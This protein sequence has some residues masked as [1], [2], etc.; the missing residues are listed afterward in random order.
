MYMKRAIWMAVCATAVIAV[1]SLHG[2]TPAGAGQVTTLGQGAAAAT[3]DADALVSRMLRSDDLRVR[4]DRD[5]TLIVGRHIEQLTQYY[6]GARVWGG[7]VARQR[8]GDTAVSVFGSI[9]QGIDLDVT[10]LLGR[11][12]AAARLLS[13]GSSLLV[14]DREPELVVLPEDGG[15]FRLVWVG[16]VLTSNNVVRFFIDANTGAVIRRYG[17]LQRQAANAALGHGT[18]VLGDDKKVSATPL[19]GTFIASDPL[20][21]PSIITYDMRG[22]F[23]RALAVIS[24]LTPIVTA[25]IASN[26]SNNWTDGAVVDAHSYSAFTYDY[27]FKRFGRRGLD[28]ANRTVRNITHLVKRSDVFTAPGDVVGQFYLNAFYCGDCAGGAM[29][30][31]E[32]LPGGV[33]LSDSGQRWDFVSGALDVVAHELTHGVTDF[34]SR[35]EYVNES[36]AL[37]ESFSDMMGTSVEFYFQPPG[38]G[39]MKADYLIGED[40]VTPAVV[41]ALSG[42][43]SMSNPALYGQPDHYSQRALLP[44]DDAHDNG[45]VHINS[46][47]PNQV[48]YLAIEGG[49]NRT[50]GLR[51]Q[52]VGAGNREQIERVFYR[53]FAQ[54]MPSNA[55]FSLARAVTLQAAQDLYGLGSAPYNAVRDAWTAVGVN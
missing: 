42:I 51:V 39:L 33:Y 29:V 32:G 31:G 45:G 6:K 48:Y 52:G 9:Y 7:D 13:Q 26:T 50:S 34:S 3:V 4:L 20:R 2:Q 17:M 21:P 44:P 11:D 1:T 43:R 30:Y 22:D 12:A 46:G 55:N 54:L 35:L 14:P 25:D 16:Q 19:S 36:G 24:N 27:Y 10:P 18:G 37:N 41:G 23:N 15:T 40:V 38:V 47:I 49:T 5:D 53:A 28:N 8:D